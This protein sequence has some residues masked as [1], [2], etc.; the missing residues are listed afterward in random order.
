MRVHVLADPTLDAS[1]TKSATWHAAA[2]IPRVDVV[3]DPYGATARAYGVATSGTVL[4][5]SPAGDLLFHGGITGARGH[6]G[7]NVGADTVVDALLGEPVST[8]S[9]PVFGCALFDDA[10]VGDDPA[11]DAPDGEHLP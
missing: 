7:D 11:Q 9:T 10:L 2:A 6:A 1:W 3:A 5:Y 8:A 4:L